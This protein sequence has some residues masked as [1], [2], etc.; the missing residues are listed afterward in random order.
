L[1]L[2]FA[3]EISAEKSVMAKIVSEELKVRAAAMKTQPIEAKWRAEL[4]DAYTWIVRQLPLP[5]TGTGAEATDSARH[6]EG[7]EEGG[8][9]I[10]RVGFGRLMLAGRLLDMTPSQFAE[11][12]RAVDVRAC[13]FVSFGDVWLWFQHAAEVKHRRMQRQKAARW[14]SEFS[15][16][17]TDILSAKERAVTSVIR[18][19]RAKSDKRHAPTA[20]SAMAGK[21]YSALATSQLYK[22]NEESNTHYCMWICLMA[23]RAFAR[24]YCIF[25]HISFP[26]L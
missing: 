18:R 24:K 15:F 26:R 10:S 7:E 9:Y 8:G 20:L 17:S 2:Q 16:K 3:D 25:C 22:V 13:G 11:G 1:S 23:H 6:T 19:Q 14:G 21:P 5:G 12:F 4:L